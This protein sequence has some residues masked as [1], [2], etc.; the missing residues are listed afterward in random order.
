MARTDVDERDL[1]LDTH[2]LLWWATGDRALSR[3]VARLLEDH[4]VTIYASAA[5]AWEI[6]TKVRLGR[7]K[8][9]SP[10]S[11]ETYC[12]GQGFTLMPVTFAQAQRAGSWPQA[13]GDPFDRL[14]AAQ[15]DLENIPLA[16][17]D[18]KIK[19]FG[20]RTIW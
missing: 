6:A 13:H 7:L 18:P 8:W 5:A 10:D 1:L 19:T 14:L 2:A 16:T 12:I 11:V 3:R 15:S 17:N 4:E 20:I 9:T